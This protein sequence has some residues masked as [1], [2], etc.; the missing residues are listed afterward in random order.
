MSRLANV[1][2]FSFKSLSPISILTG[3]PF[4]SLSA[5]LNPG[6]FSESSTYTVIPDDFSLLYVSSVS[7]LTA[8]DSPIGTITTCLGAILGGKTKPFSSLCTI[9]KAPIILVV[10]PHE[11][12]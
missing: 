3:I 2:L 6:D 1:I 5:N 12:W 7:F 8:S 4:T 9:I 10:V 11:V